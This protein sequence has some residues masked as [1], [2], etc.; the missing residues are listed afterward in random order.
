MI[1]FNTIETIASS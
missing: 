1:G